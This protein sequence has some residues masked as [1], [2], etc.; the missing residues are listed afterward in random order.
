MRAGGR[1]SAGAACRCTNAFPGSSG[2][3]GGRPAAASSVSDHTRRE[4]VTLTPATDC[5]DRASSARAS[6]VGL[7]TAGRRGS[8]AGL[9]RLPSDWRIGARDPASTASSASASGGTAQMIERLL[10]SC[11]ALAVERHEGELSL[12]TSNAAAIRGWPRQPAATQASRSGLPQVR[13]APR[14]GSPILSPAA[15]RSLLEVSVGD[16]RAGSSGVRRQVHLDREAALV[17]RR[18]ERLV[19]GVRP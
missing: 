3:P 17:Q 5:A 9:R 16:A 18:V 8:A 15:R 7:E 13:I 1:E 2:R 12:A 10:A 4:R 19:D 14:R 11:S 6:S